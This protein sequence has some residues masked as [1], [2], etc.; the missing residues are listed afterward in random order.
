M[1]S[2]ISW[3]TMT[4]ALLKI[5]RRFGWSCRLLLHR[6]RIRQVRNLREAGSKQRSVLGR[7]L[8]NIYIK[9]L[10]DAITFSRYVLF[11][12]DIKIYRALQSPDDYNLVQFD[13]N[14]VQGWRIANCVK[15]KIN[16]TEFM[17][18]SRRTN[19]LLYE[20]KLYQFRIKQTDYRRPW[21]ITGFWQPYP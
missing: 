10:C 13:I 14:T 7:L 17:F 5:N 3:D 4:C 1:K 11:A 18:F 9:D 16:K 2:S 19:I 20:H 21:S 15:L 8:F 6:R 12:P